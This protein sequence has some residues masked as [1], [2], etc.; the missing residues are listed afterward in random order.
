FAT[1]TVERGSD[2][3]QQ[4][5]DVHARVVE[6]LGIVHGV[7]HTEFIRGAAD[8]RVYFLETAARVGGAHIADLVDASSGVN[9]WREWAKLELLQG[10]HPYAPPE[11][12]REYGGLLISLARQEVPDTSGYNDPEIAWRLKDHA[13]HVGF[14]LRSANRARVEELLDSYLARVAHDF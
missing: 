1:R 11:R 2:L 12:R 5:L 4:I 8:G 13:H 10:E 3:E 6:H 9:L 7:A 14:V